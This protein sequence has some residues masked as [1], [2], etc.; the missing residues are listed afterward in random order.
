VKPISILLV[1]T[2]GHRAALIDDGPCGS[3]API[4]YQQGNS[5]VWHAWEYR[6]PD[7]QMPPR[8]ALVLAWDGKPV[9]DGLARAKLQTSFAMPLSNWTL[10][11]VESFAYRVQELNIGH[12]VLLDA[13]GRGVGQ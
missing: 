4:A 2:A 13:D 12:V 8:T 9:P 5:L 1:P 10:S 11:Q 7:Q 3:A 6:D